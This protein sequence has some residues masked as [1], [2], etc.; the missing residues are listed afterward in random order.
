MG[1]PI[2]DIQLETARG[3]GKDRY[4]PGPEFGSS[5]NRTVQT[6]KADIRATTAHASSSQVRWR[7]ASIRR[8]R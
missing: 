8:T 3:V 7:D 1:L 4:R 2:A 6:A 5:R